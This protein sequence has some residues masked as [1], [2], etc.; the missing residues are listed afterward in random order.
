M[1]KILPG[2]LVGILLGAAATWFVLRSPETAPRAE[3]APTKAEPEKESPLH[4]PPA[5]RAAAGIAL[6][7][8]TEREMASEVPAFARVLD[9]TPLV[10]L[11]AEIET[12]R[13]TSEASEKEAERSRQLFAAEGNVSAQA[14]EGAVAATARDRAAL[15]SARAR[16]LAGWGREIAANPTAV[17]RAL[18]AGGSL[19]RLDALPGDLIDAAA[20]TA[21]IRWSETE[22]VSIELLG[23]ARTADPQ[24]QGAG[25]LGL[26]RDRAMPAGAVLRATLP[27]A[28]EASKVLVL[29]RSAIVYH[30]GSAWVFVLGEEDTFERKLVTVG[31]SVDDES[32]AV[33]G[34]ELADQVVTTG[35]QQLLAAELQAGGAP[36][37]E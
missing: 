35:A 8:P 14:V 1:K 34:I 36:A 33:Q 15:A 13:A 17:A 23:P 29:P 12:A 18:E 5:K 32:V 19:V 11:L 26:M 37:E 3:V 30:Q 6:T 2:I 28:A 21:R 4:F 16:L 9:P 7:K 31:R 24:V 27:G 20:K 25:F 10:T 22:S